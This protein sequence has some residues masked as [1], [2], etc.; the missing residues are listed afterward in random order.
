MAKV[1]K[2]KRKQPAGSRG[3]GAP[4]EPR[5]PGADDERDLDTTE[6]GASATDDEARDGEA[7][8]AAAED[9]RDADE[10]RDEDERDADERRDEGEP[11]ESDAAPAPTASGAGEAAAEGEED[12][13]GEAEVAAGQLGAGRWVAVG[14]IA[15]WLL[16]AY[17]LGQ[18]LTGL[19]AWA[20]T[21]DFFSRNLPAFAAVPHEGELFSRS[22]LSLAIGGLVAGLLTLYYY[23]KAT[24]RTWADEVADEVGKVK[25]PTRKE[26]TSNTV[27]VLVVSAV[28]TLYLTVL[29]RLWGFVTNLVYST[30]S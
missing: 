25:W 21:R 27:T 12:E 1:G 24:V 4:V 22:T 2:K 8:R 20:S 16:A 11:D 30:G 10:R 6:A 23:R 9:E 14:F 3:T 7:A 26:T 29:D 15:M 5:T 28:I 19:W 13:E 18:A 17:V